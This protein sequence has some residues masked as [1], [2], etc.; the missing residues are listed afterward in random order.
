M[1]YDNVE[2]IDNLRI[3]V[4]GLL[5][6]QIVTVDGKYSKQDRNSY[7]RRYRRRH[8]R[9]HVAETTTSHPGRTTDESE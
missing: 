2:Y 5:Y 4:N 7:M 1:M 8:R 6:R 9:D 3:R